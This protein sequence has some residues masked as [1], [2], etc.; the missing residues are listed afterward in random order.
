MIV[1]GG[2]R[3]G[4]L[5]CWVGVGGLGGWGGGGGEVEKRG[6]G[7]KSNGES[8]RKSGTMQTKDLLNKLSPPLSFPIF[9]FYYLSLPPYLSSHFFFFSISTFGLSFSHFLFSFFSFLFYSEL[10]S[11]FVILSLSFPS[12]S[13]S[14]SYLP[15]SLSPLFLC[16]RVNMTKLLPKYSA[17]SRTPQT[18]FSILAVFCICYAASSAHLHARDT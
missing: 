1:H 5:V 16:A 13:P 8:N 7:F 12:I 3:G 10:I 4:T 6:E 9:L 15:P 14:L 18:F 17:E 11:F 2:V